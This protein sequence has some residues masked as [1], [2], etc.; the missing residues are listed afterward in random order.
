MHAVCLLCMLFEVHWGLG[1]VHARVVLMEAAMLASTS[2][3]WIVHVCAYA[4]VKRQGPEQG[5]KRCVASEDSNG[6]VTLRQLTQG[7]TSS[8]VTREVREPAA[9]RVRRRTDDV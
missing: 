3:G 9:G 5:A 7:Q 8:M 6:R 2:A 1:Q 4:S